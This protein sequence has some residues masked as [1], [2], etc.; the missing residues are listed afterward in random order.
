MEITDIKFRH[1]GHDSRLRALV[2]ITLDGVLA[3]HDIKIIEGQ[4]RYFLAM[5][6]KKMPN[7]KFRDIVH[8]VGNE[9]REKIEA[10]VLSLFEKELQG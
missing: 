2:S 3:L 4:D 9:L 5:P 7:G 1:I 8:P 6:A 10:S